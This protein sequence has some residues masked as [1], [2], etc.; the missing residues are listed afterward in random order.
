MLSTKQKQEISIK[1]QNILQ[2]IVD[3]E[4]P[5]GEIHFI[6]HIDGAE[7]WSWAN[8]RNMSDKDL[9]V[10]FSLVRNIWTG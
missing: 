3:D 4:L 8:I 7:P 5:K 1:V 6:L 10:P 2:G 9:N